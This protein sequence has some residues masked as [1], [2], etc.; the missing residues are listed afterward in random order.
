MRHL[1]GKQAYEMMNHHV[2]MWELDCEESWVLKN[3]CFFKN[4]N[5]FILIGG[6]GLSQLHEKHSDGMTQHNCSK[7]GKTLGFYIP[8]WLVIDTKYQFFHLICM[9]NAIPIKI[10]ENYFLSLLVCYAQQ[11]NSKVYTERQKN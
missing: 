6:W 9:S 10:L 8:I 1:D 2:W 11:I 7:T 3:L 4:L 5:L